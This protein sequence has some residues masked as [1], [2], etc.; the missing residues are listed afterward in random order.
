MADDSDTEVVINQHNEGSERYLAERDELGQGDV[1]S[2]QKDDQEPYLL[3]SHEE[4]GPEVHP[5]SMENYR[6]ISFA[7]KAGLP[8]KPEP[9]SGSEDWEEY[10]SHF[11]LC[12]EVGKWSEQERVLALA[13]SLRGPARTFYISL[14]K[15]EKYNYTTLVND[16]SQGFGSSR[17]QSRW[18]SRLEDRK[19]KQDELIASLGDDLR[20]MSQRAH[21]NLDAR[22][23]EALALNQLY[24]YISL[25]MKCR[26][27]DRN[28]LTIA[29]A[30]DI[31]ER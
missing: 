9:Y 22:A 23:Q 8:V 13:A 10:I 20:Q 16:L 5:M 31:I 24:K 27:I 17:Q 15:E 29:Q 3:R 18:V 26:C 30:V 14:P 12:S 2:Q 11:T 28:C 21:P 1:Y 25:E 7:K 4:C 6:E 19:R